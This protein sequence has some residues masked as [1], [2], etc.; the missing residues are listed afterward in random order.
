[1][2]TTFVYGDR[3]QCKAELGE[4]TRVAGGVRQAAPFVADPVAAVRAALASPA[5]YPPLAS[6]TVPGDR[7]AVTLADDIPERDAVLTGAIAALLDAGVEAELIT[8]V[9]TNDLADD[10]DLQSRLVQIRAGGVVFERHDP[11]D[12]DRI[13]MIGVNGAGE[14]LRI[15]RTVAEADLVLPIST[16]ESAAEGDGASRFS[17]LFP[18]FSN[19]ETINRLKP[20]GIKES[21]KQR[22]K[23]KAEIDDAGWK[24]GVGMT[25]RVIA[26]A[27]GT[28]AAIEAGD[29]TAVDRATQRRSHEVW[30]AAVERLGDLVVVA[31]VGDDRQQ[32]W[33]NLARALRTAES[34][35]SAGGAIAV[36]SAITA[37]PSRTFSVLRDAVDFEEA[38]SEIARTNAD[39]AAAAM[40]LAQALE[41]GPVYL[42]SQLPADVVESLGMTPFETD[43]ELSRLAAMRGH[44]VLIED[45]QR[46]TIKSMPRD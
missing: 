36:C 46:V 23:R 43:Q 30:D 5:G 9:A 26:G 45:A 20:H 6:A 1:M 42:R 22:S 17:G 27:G 2:M 35:L 8:V 38:Q 16:C 33:D 14:P 25:M 24:L 41:R 37:H 7:V 11:G 29:P 19:R 31:I 12:D 10:K 28:I 34:A 18:Q 44:C 15:N 3:Q 32:T 13:A 4:C 40:A 39:D 21:A